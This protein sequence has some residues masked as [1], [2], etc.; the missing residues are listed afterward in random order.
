[1]H[2]VY[3]RYPNGTFESA[4]FVCACLSFLPP[5]SQTRSRS[6]SAY[7]FLLSNKKDQIISAMFKSIFFKS[8]CSAHSRRILLHS[9]L[10]FAD[11][12][13]IFVCNAFHSSFASSTTALTAALAFLYADFPLDLTA[14]KRLRSRSKS[15]VNFFVISSR[16]ARI[17]CSSFSSWCAVSS[18]KRLEVWTFSETS[19]ASLLDAFSK[20]ISRLLES[21]CTLDS[22]SRVLVRRSVSMAF[23]IASNWFSAAAA[24]GRSSSSSSSSSSFPKSSSLLFR[25]T[26]LVAVAARFFTR[27]SDSFYEENNNKP[28]SS[29]S[30]SS[31]RYAKSSLL[32]SSSSPRFLRFSVDASSAF[33]PVEN[34]NLRPIFALL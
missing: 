9:R 23:L 24:E 15:R 16:R 31:S 3:A 19:R 29:S 4:F 1:M 34:F 5:F 8:V 28:S 17:F 14:S 2:D 10:N 20:S 32:S 26:T 33:F 12:S 30:S 18:M 25:P 7:N 27:S 21:F 13:R 22:A 6:F 11:F